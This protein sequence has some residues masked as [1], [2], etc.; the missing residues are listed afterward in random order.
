MRGATIYLVFFMCTLYFGK[1]R[2]RSD[3]GKANEGNQLEK[4]RRGAANTKTE[5]MSAKIKQ[6]RKNFK[7]LDE[8]KPKGKMGKK[9]KTTNKRGKKT[10][11]CR[12]KSRGGK[13]PKKN[14]RYYHENGKYKS[15][16]K[17]DSWADE[18]TKMWNKVRR[19]SSCSC[20]LSTVDRTRI[21]NGAEAK[22]HSYPWIVAMMTGSGDYYCG[23]SIISNEWILTAAHCV[24]GEPNNPARDM[25]VRVGDHDMTD[26]GDSPKAD[27]FQVDFYIHHAKYN[28]KTTNNDIALL[29]LKKKI[30]FK[31]YSG[32]VTPVCLPD[33]PRKYYGETVTVSGWGLLSDGG[34]AAKKLREVD[35]KII[36]MKQCR[37]NFHYKKSWISS[38]MMCTF[39]EDAD[40]CQ[41]DSGGPLVRVNPTS[42]RYEQVGVVSWGIGCASPKYPGV[43]VKL[44][45]YLSWILKKTSKSTF[46]S[47]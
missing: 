38:K 46:C 22:A 10:K 34:N 24:S 12:K 5:M 7:L 39:K 3:I 35:L 17:F 6:L 27:T 37:E 36:W 41:G 8:T 25:Y 47:R 28:E 43:F 30:D 21:V 11:S 23:G 29:K 33:L 15:N 26:K 42:G 4:S 40:A 2:S 19:D 44:S 9:C 1:G 18:V 16:E 32:T 45:H 13:R 31:K 20:G 14:A